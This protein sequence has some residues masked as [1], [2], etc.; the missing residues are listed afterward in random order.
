MA[1]LIII[2]YFTYVITFDGKY[3][4]TKRSNIKP[5]NASTGKILLWQS[6]VVDIK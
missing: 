5:Q 4:R 3:M 1:L 6:I 2:I